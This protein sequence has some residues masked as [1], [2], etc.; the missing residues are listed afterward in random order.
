MVR[1][2]T[3]SQPTNQVSSHKIKQKTSP[4]IRSQALHNMKLQLNSIQEI[5]IH[6]YGLWT[7]LEVVHSLFVLHDLHPDS[8]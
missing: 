7:V 5:H 8:N 2:G 1:L 4:I 3:Q 6:L